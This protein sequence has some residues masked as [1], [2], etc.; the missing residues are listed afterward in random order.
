MCTKNLHGSKIINNNCVV[1]TSS[2]SPAMLHVSEGLDGELV[3]EHLLTQAPGE[4]VGVVTLHRG[5]Q[6]QTELE[7][8]KV[9]SFE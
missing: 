6:G 9:L 1:I 2:D 7:L 4:R 8:R 5:V 3:P